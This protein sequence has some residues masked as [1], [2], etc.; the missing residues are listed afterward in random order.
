MFRFAW[1]RCVMGLLVISCVTHAAFAQSDSAKRPSPGSGTFWIFLTTGKSTSGTERVE[2]EKMQA[3]HVA[4]FGR[5][6]KEGKLLT[7]GPIA[8]PQKKKRGIVVLT[9]TDLKSMPALFDP[10]PYVTQGFLTVD[11]IKMDIAVGNFQKDADPNKF[12]EYRLVL[13][14]K[15]TPDGKEV[16]AQTVS[17]NLEYCRGI[18]DA[19]R[20]CFAGLLK[21]DNLSRR[22]ILIFRKL[23]DAKLK[24]LVDELPAVKSNTWTSKTFPLYMTD[25]IVK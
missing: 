4:N 6:F 21:E 1:L 9:G 23:D 24:S 16:D 7:A 12:T 17:K 13:L 19:E 18:H 8:D 5:L 3:A 15:P 2:V 20:L 25:G 10:D 22:G 14:E 11:A